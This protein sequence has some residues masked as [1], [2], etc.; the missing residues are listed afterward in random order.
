MAKFRE[1][2][3]SSAIEETQ[4]NS[5]SKGKSH[6]IFKRALGSHLLDQPGGE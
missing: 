4:N 3:P 1:N 6:R 5:L 2:I